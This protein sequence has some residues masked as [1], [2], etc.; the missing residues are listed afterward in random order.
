MVETILAN[1]GEILSHLADLCEVI[2]IVLAI[3]DR[4]REKKDDRQHPTNTGGQ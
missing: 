2:V 3:Y 4:V 1:L